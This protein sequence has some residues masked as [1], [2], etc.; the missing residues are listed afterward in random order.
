MKIPD[1]I[2]ILGIPYK[3]KEIPSSALGPQKKEQALLHEMIHGM[4]YAFDH[5]FDNEQLVQSLASTLHQV[6][7][8]NPLLFI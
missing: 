6:I 8:D 4:L 5:Q 1:T 3:V 7:K 2:K